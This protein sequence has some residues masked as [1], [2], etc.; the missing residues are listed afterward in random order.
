MP[1]THPPYAPECI[2]T[3]DKRG[4]VQALS[5]LRQLDKD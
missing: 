4:W 1:R 2:E 3:V 5:L